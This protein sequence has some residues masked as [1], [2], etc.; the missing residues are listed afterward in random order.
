MSE[1]PPG[2]NPDPNQGPNPSPGPNQGIPNAGPQGPGYV[3]YPRYNQRPA[4][5]IFNLD[6]VGPS[7]NLLT[8]DFGKW[9]INGLIVFVAIAILYGSNI[10]ISFGTNL[11]TVG[12]SNPAGAIAGF[13]ASLILGAIFACLIQTVL[14]LGLAGSYRMANKAIAG[15]PLDGSDGFSLGENPGGVFLA[16]L[17]AG[18]GVTLA[19]YACCIPGLFVYPLVIF[20]PLFA[21]ERNLSGAQAIQASFELAK[22][23]VLMGALVCFVVSFLS[24][25]G[26]LA[27][28]IGIIVTMPLSWIIFVWL[29]RDGIG[30]QYGQL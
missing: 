12:A 4:G 18:V 10:L 17:I 22:P 25:L 30:K 29:F 6:S 27:C 16:S 15:F 3:N 1:T 24:G 9:A 28:F 11:A 13:G 14:F 21:I 5:A 20:A 7:W 8:K 19:Y 2:Q 26:S 23:G